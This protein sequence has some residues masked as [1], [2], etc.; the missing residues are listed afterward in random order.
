MLAEGEQYGLECLKTMCEDALYRELSVEIAAHTLILS[1]LHNVGQ[2]KTHALDF[3]TVHASEVSETESW[4]AMLGSYPL[5]V[6]ESHFPT[7]LFH[8]VL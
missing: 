7:L 8:R 6:A 2:M 3:I 4:K 1:D 5:L